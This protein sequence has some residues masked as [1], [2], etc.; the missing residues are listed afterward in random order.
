MLC[1]EV[2]SL[3]TNIPLDKT[4]DICT[5]KLFQNPETLH[6]GISNN[7]FLD[8]LDLATKEPFFTFNNHI[9]IQIDSVAMESPLG[10]ILTNIFL[11]RHEERWI[12]KLPIEFKASF[13]RKYVNDICLLFESPES[14]RSFCEYKS[15]K[16]QNT[17]ANFEHDDMGLLSFIDVKICC[18]NAKFITSYYKKPL[19][20]EAF[21]NYKVSFQHIKN[22]TFMH[23]TS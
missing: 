3:F 1:L 11:S 19:F 23:I 12:I 9:Y 13:Y 22:K 15:S 18:K 20:S 21:T 4:I 8:L 6:N 14:A 2:D 17:N 16:H 5:S 7:D 10:Q